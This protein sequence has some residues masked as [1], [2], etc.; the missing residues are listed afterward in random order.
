MQSTL[1][2]KVLEVITKQNAETPKYRFA[3]AQTLNNNKVRNLKSS[4]CLLLKH[5]C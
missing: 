3:H 5:P 4:V 2:V 1:F